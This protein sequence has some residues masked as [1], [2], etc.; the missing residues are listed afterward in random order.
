MHYFITKPTIQS[1][2]L[3]VSEYR[4]VHQM[5]RVLRLR[6]WDFCVIQREMMRYICQIHRYSYSDVQLCVV[7]TI[8]G[9]GWDWDLSWIIL[10]VAL[11]Q[12]LST[13]ELVTQKCTEIGIDRIMRCSSQRSQ[14]RDINDT[15]LWRISTIALE[16][17]EQSHRWTIPMIEFVDW[18]T[19]INMVINHRS[20]IFSLIQQDN[21]DTIPTVRYNLWLV[22]PEWWRTLEEEQQLIQCWAVSRTLWQTVLRMETACIVWSRRLTQQPS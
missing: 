19:V 13:V 20:V 3:I 6:Q 17:A 16:A 7:D 14:L 4:V 12:Q 15:K 2:Q 8:S 22:G 21:T 5:R 11:P 9:S 10:I 18:N 1:E